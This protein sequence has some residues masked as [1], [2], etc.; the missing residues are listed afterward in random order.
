MN[1]HNDDTQNFPFCKSKL[2]VETFE[3]SN[4]IQVKS[5]KLLSQRI[6]KHY[7]KTLGTSL[8]NSQMSPPSLKKTTQLKKSLRLKFW[9]QGKLL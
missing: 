9:V 6:R 7:D 3:H 8:I 2:V 1:V 5:P 4:K